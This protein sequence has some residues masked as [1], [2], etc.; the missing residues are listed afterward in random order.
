MNMNILVVNPPNKPFT[1]KSILAEP[2]DVL[3]IATI[4]KEKYHNVRVIDMDVNRMKNNINCYLKDNNIIIFIYDYQ[5]PLHTSEAVSNIFDII[6]NTNQKSKFIIIGKTSSYF[7]E[8]FLDNGI[9]VIINGIADKTIIKVIDSI[10][11]NKDLSLIPNI[12]IK[13]D[14][15][16]IHTKQKRIEN[17]YNLL[18]KPDRSLVDVKK[19]MDTRTIISSRG[20]VG[21]CSFCTTPSYFGTWVGKDPK[22]V[23]DEIEDLIKKYNTKKIIFLD[24]NMTVNKERMFEICNEIKN[25]N[26]KCLFG[27]LSSIACYD[28][29]MFKKMYSVGFRWIHFGIESGSER[30]LKLMNKHMK[31]DYVKQVIKETKDMGYRVRNSIILDYPTTT[32]DDLE[33]TKSLIKELLPHELRLHYLAYRVGTKVFK[34]NKNVTN[35][36]QYIHSN[37]PNI[38]NNLKK[39]INK[40]IKELEKIGYIIVFNEVDW[41]K[42]NLLDKETKIASFLP[43]KYGMCW[44]E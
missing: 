13:E 40:F 18:K 35:N 2:L 44:Y 28:R 17:K 42:Y 19:Y 10:I 25:R 20:C 22:K 37:K 32:K 30:I 6:K 3:Q 8:K 7:F 27:C 9:D 38:E 36:T 43:T 16:I 23:V 1:N 5:L 14:N 29:L 26:I 34:E 4:I 39:E 31:I 15:K 33:A 24:D 41:N 11:E 21:K 12:I